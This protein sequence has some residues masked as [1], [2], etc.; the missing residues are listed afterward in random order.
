[1]LSCIHYNKGSPKK[2]IYHITMM[3]GRVGDTVT[4]PVEGF[5]IPC[6]KPLTA[7]PAPAR[8]IAIGDI[9]GDLDLMLSCLWIAGLIERMKVRDRNTVT[10]IYKD[11]QPRYYKWVGGKTVV[12]QVGDQ[13]D[14]CRPMPEEPCYHPHTTQHDEASDEKILTFFTELHEVAKMHGGAV[15]S[16]LG[17]H[18]LLNAMGRYSY[19]S[20]LGL[21]EYTPQGQPV[22]EY[23][24]G[25]HFKRGKRLSHLMACSRSSV[26]IIGSY[27]FV[28][29]G[30]LET[31]VRELSL[32]PEARRSTDPKTALR[33]LNELVQKWLRDPKY[34]S[35][36]VNNIISGINSPFLVRGLGYIP[37][38]QS[39]DHPACQNL[40]VVLDFFR[41]KGMVVGHTPQLEDGINATCNK[42]LFRVDIASSAAFDRVMNLT[43]NPVW[44][45][46]R[47]PQVLEILNDCEVNVIRMGEREKQIIKECHTK[48]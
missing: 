19:V 34:T 40:Q 3:K 38:N 9:H 42:S 47:K 45:H 2:Y 1:M 37:T 29:A 4:T 20:Y 5:H 16:L 41:L 12:I 48:K 18:E 43:N 21:A 23:W 39:N 35:Q 33:Y 31:L 7:I 44:N 11:G 27:L 6:A 32:I 26:M 17:N 8:L 13:V 28:H 24:R 36:S 10:L 14:R 46:N 25:E 22:T 30:F 15:Y